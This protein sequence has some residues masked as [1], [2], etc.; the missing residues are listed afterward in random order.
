MRKKTLDKLR[1]IASNLPVNRIVKTKLV[2]VGRV[3]SEPLKVK[4]EYE[5]YVGKVNHLKRL[6]KAYRNG[7]VKGV[8]KYVNQA[9]EIALFQNKEKWR[10]SISQQFSLKSKTLKQA[11]S[12]SSMS[13]QVASKKGRSENSKVVMEAQLISRPNHLQRVIRKI[14]TLIRNGC[15]S[16]KGLFRFIIPSKVST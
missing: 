1:A 14:S 2:R 15:T 5:S 8:E 7:G 3:P 9:H 13:N 6:K 11:S 4:K 10:K 16:I 12:N